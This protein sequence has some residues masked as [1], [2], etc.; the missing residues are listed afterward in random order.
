MSRLPQTCGHGWERAAPPHVFV[1]PDLFNH[2]N[3][4]AELFVELGFRRVRVAEYQRD[5]HELD[6]DLYE[7]T[8]PTAARALF[9]HFRGRGQP[10]AN[11]PGRNV[12]NAYQVILQKGPCFVQVSNATGSAELVPAMAT[13]AAEIWHRLPTDQPIPLLDRLPA[14][15]RIANTARIIRGPVG[16]DALFP[17]GQGDVLKLGGRTFAVAADY[18]TPRDETYTLL[19]VPY[20]SPAAA[21][22]A[23]DHLRMNLDAYYQIITDERRRLVFRDLDD[24]FGIV[25]RKDHV[26]AL[27]LAAP[28]P[29]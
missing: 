12:G 4:A 21:R 1:G 16:L 20:D 3:G 28:T 5:G 15:D 8:S 19:I 2:I 18:Q 26:L 11:V 23:L 27:K 6:L 14:T 25:T 24:R 9:Y 22:A 13:L 29:P 10:A 17:L 7:M